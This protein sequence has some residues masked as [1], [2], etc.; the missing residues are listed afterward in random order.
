M[1]IKNHKINGVAIDFGKKIVLSTIWG[2]GSYSE[3][4]RL[5]EK[6]IKDKKASKEKAITESFENRDYDSATVEVYALKIPE[7]I[8]KKL[9]EKYKN[10]LSSEKGLH[11]GYFPIDKWIDLVCQLKNS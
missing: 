2:F 5:D 1:K 6:L 11:L 8:A 4:Y 9:R 7:K 3:G 10:Y